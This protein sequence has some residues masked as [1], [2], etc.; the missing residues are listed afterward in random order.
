MFKKKFA[1]IVLLVAIL[2]CLISGIG[3]RAVKTDGNNVDIHDIRV[4]TDVGVLTGQLYVPKTATPSSPKPAVVL[5]HG[6]LNSSEMQD[7]NAVELARRDFVVLSVNMYA[8]G[9][10]TLHDYINEFVDGPF[11][12][13]FTANAYGLYDAVNYVY[14]LEFVDKTKVGLA[15]H[16]L[17][18]LSANLAV[19]L[20]DLWVQAQRDS[21][22]IVN[23]K[24]ASVLLMGADAN[25]TASNVMDGTD[26][27]STNYYGARH[28]G[29]IAAQYDEFFF[30][31]A[32]YPAPRDFLN[33]ENAHIFVNSID[34]SSQ[35]LA[36]TPI[37]NALADNVNGY[38]YGTVDY[39]GSTS[40]Q[41]YMRVIYNP[42]EIH[43]ANHFSIA[44]TGAV[45]EFFS[46]AASSNVT[47][48]PVDSASGLFAQTWWIK[49]MFNFIGLIG[50]FMFI[51][52]FALLLT[53]TSFF[54][55]LRVSEEPKLHN[56]PVG[57]V[58]LFTYWG[59]YALTII[60]S[61]VTFLY[62]TQWINRVGEAG[63]PGVS[64]S[65]TSYFT[66]PTT[67]EFVAWAVANAIIV[68]GIYLIS[69]L[70]N[71]KFKKVD[72]SMT[73]GQLDGVKISPVKLG[74]TLLLALL[75]L[76]AAFNLVFFNEFFFNTDFRIW[77]LAVKVFEQY[78]LIT[79][80]KYVLLFAT[81]FIASSFVINKSIARAN[82]KEWLN[83][84]IS[85]VGITG[86]LLIIVIVQYLG[87]R[88]TGERTFMDQNLRPIL[89]FAT[90]P[91]LAITAII[92]RILYRKT[93][94][95]WL[96]AFINTMLIT[97][98]TVA[99]TATFLA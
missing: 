32:D 41:Q 4:V 80:A 91:L 77:T 30:M 60:L 49:E 92:S 21:G 93:G 51:I 26:P 75:T 46:K 67:N 14:N 82:R 3:A 17:G 35:V 31:G 61:A 28:V 40:A 29:I 33:G 99:N 86:G 36:T 15:G 25:Y 98:I 18:G 20:D 72:Q 56:K 34:L 69:N 22:N 12:P 42:S 13:L 39:F 66:Q 90:I 87:F 7:S 97:M 70:I 1:I 83:I 88:I 27:I 2:L 44:S 19:Y 53:K 63:F 96:G 79:A 54:A 38:Y 94:S 78:H 84:L 37:I 8:H 76:Y 11:V 48:L 55:P 62:V 45:V 64:A 74:K 58:S 5:S 47:L 6:Y 23:S 9:A 68:I 43:P 16:S 85:V 71:N 52:P 57:K 24:I 50:F 89:A 81:F 59:G 95:I 65:V 73:I 10:S